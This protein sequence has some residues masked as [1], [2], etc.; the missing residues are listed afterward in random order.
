[1]EVNVPSKRGQ[2]DTIKHV[3]IIHS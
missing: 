1:M 2:Q 3:Y